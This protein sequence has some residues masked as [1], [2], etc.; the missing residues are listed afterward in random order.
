MTQLYVVRVN[1]LGGSVAPKPEDPI[2]E[3][4]M[5]EL[6]KFL[7]RAAE[8]AGRALASKRLILKLQWEWGEAHVTPLGERE[9]LAFILAERALSRTAHIKRE[10]RAPA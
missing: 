4:A 3:N 9:Y 1:G 2:T 10:A 5:V 7:G 8:A 6:V